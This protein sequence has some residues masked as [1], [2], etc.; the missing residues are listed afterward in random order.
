METPQ[1]EAA[2]LAL[3][4]AVTRMNRESTFMPT[5]P[6]DERT[7]L[8]KDYATLKEMDPESDDIQSHNVLPEYEHRP[9][10]LEHYCLV[11]FVSDLRIEYSKN[12]TFEDPIDDNFD[13][14]LLDPAKGNILDS[15]VLEIP[16][17]IVIK[18]RRV[19]RILKY[20]NYNIKR[21]P[22]NYY[23]E[24]LMLFLLWRNEEDDLSGGFQTHE[25]HHMAKQS[26]IAPIRKKYEKFNDS[27]ELA[28]GEVG[29]ADLD[30]MY[31]MDA[32][33]LNSDMP[34]CDKGDYGFFDPDR[35][36]EQRQYDIG[37]DMGMGEKYATEVNYLTAPMPNEEYVELMQSLNLRQSEICAHVMQW[38]QA[39][40]GPM[41]IFIEGGAGVGKTKAAKAIYESMNRFYSTQPG[42][43]S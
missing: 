42:G 37:H 36:E 33:I 8:L 10:A 14:D 41:Y 35:P 19:P 23:R 32:A 25:E 21:D 15:Q 12:V 28:I 1:Q 39:R 2:F 31:D 34:Q 29:N 20:V 7:F 17:G 11:A 13:D 4:M 27:L 3:Q 9:R 38:I 40:T 24:R 30:D 43:R 18:K 26:L 6:P 16:N 22:E 5:P